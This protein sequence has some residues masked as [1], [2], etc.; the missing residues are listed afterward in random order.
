[1]SARTFKEYCNKVQADWT[2]STPA[3]SRRQKLS[4]LYRVT[5]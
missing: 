2:H 5:R 3:K 1:M 4:M